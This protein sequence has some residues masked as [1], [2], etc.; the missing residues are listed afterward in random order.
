[1]DG[2]IKNGDKIRFMAN[3]KDFE[4]IE[5]GYMKPQRTSANELKTGEVGYLAASIKEICQL[6]GDTVTHTE[7]PAKE[8]LP[9]YKKAVPM[10]FCGMYPVV[11]D[12]YHELKES[13]EKLKLND[14]SIT[15]ERKLLLHWIWIQMRIF[16]ASAYGN[17]TGKARREYNISLITTAPSVVYHVY[18]AMEKFYI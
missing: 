3:K 4:V 2:K 10:V 13:L 16:G 12:Q 8:A 6:V 14:S 1:M 17:C 7:H 9:G 5:L 15:F 11:N 18:K